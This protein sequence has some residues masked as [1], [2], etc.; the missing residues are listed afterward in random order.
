MK[1]SLSRIFSLSSFEGLRLIRSYMFKNVELDLNNLIE[2]IQRI[3]ADSE[4]LDLDVGL[5][6]HKIVDATCVLANPEFYQEC[7]KSIIVNHRPSWIM[8]MKQGRRRFVSTLEKEEQ[9]IFNAAG[10]MDNPPSTK[11][12][13]W[14]DDIAGR[15]RLLTDL[16]KMCQARKAERLSF[17]YEMKQLEDIGIEISPIWQGL[18]DNFAGYDILSYE[19]NGTN[20]CNKLIEVKST[21]ASPQRFIVTR[22]EWEKAIQSEKYVFHVWNMMKNPEVLYI[23]TVESIVPHIPKDN[24]KGTWKTVEIPL[25]I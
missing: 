11:T 19:K 15:A 18:D 21:I 25:G 6:L 4:H 17:N 20:I 3:E 22:N 14:W 13:V 9:D 7:I 2:T 12:V 8:L 23:K 5:Y 24:K 16:E 1:F 10:L